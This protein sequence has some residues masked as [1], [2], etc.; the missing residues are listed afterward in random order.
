MSTPCGE[1]CLEHPIQPCYAQHAPVSIPRPVH[2]GA[3]LRDLVREHVAVVVV[4]THAPPAVGPPDHLRSEQTWQRAG[5]V[6]RSAAGSMRYPRC[7]LHA[8][9]AALHVAGYILHF[10]MLHGLCFTLR[11]GVLPALNRCCTVH[12]SR[13]CMLATSL[14]KWQ[15]SPPVRLSSPFV[16]NFS[17]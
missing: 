11:G 3:D 12:G 7:M 16:R 6:L 14:R 8:V 9:C 10:A 17:R 1:R 4:R 13:T 2:R 15:S 5:C